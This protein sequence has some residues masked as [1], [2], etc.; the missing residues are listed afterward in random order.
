MRRR[1]LNGE[2]EAPSDSITLHAERLVKVQLH[3]APSACGGGARSSGREE[4]VVSPHSGTFLPS[5]R[6]SHTFLEARGEQSLA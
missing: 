4:G 2:T 3:G 5:L 1:S 6:S